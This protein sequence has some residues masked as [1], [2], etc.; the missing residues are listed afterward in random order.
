MHD[1]A[2]SRNYLHGPSKSSAVA[3]MLGGNAALA[4]G[5]WMVRLAEIG[6]AASAFWRLAIALPFL[7]LAARLTGQTL[8]RTRWLWGILCLA[9]LF[10]AADLIAWHSGILL[11]K[12]ANAT[13][14]GNAASFFFVAYGF[15]VARRLPQRQQWIAMALAAGGAGLLLGRSYDLSPQYLTGDLL[16]LLGGLF[17]AGYLVAIDRARGQVQSWPALAVATAGGTLPLL[18]VALAAGPVIP[19]HWTPLVMLAI[20]SQIVGQGLMVYAIGH[21][22]PMVIGLG[23]LT[24]PAIA[25]AIGWLAYSERLDGLDFLGMAAIGLAIILARS[26]ER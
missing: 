15:I 19:A 23:L 12:L 16:C 9:G 14:F 26:G 22:S 7:V 21:L 18:F 2:P 13:M 25:A 5:P 4:L 17:Y 24:Q 11:T 1:S 6:P 3:A 8:P 10:F 20:G